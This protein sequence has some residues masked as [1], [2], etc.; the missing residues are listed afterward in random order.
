VLA[1]YI[2]FVF[3]TESDCTLNIGKNV[4]YWSGNKEFVMEGKCE[5]L[6]ISTAYSL[7]PLSGKKPIWVDDANEE[8]EDVIW[9]DT[10]PPP[11]S[12]WRW[13]K[14]RHIHPDFN[15]A[16][17]A[18]DELYAALNVQFIDESLEGETFE[19][20]DPNARFNDIVMNDWW[21]DSGILKNR[22]ARIKQWLAWLN[23][24]ASFYAPTRYM[25]DFTD[26]LY[27]AVLHID[28]KEK[29]MIKLPK[30]VTLEGEV[31]FGNGL[32]GKVIQ[33]DNGISVF[34]LKQYQENAYAPNFWAIDYLD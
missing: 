8:Y 32:A 12:D 11:C 28:K 3:L 34:G 14:L 4:Q 7:S 17:S 16:G 20:L 5:Y 2:P 19:V 9:V 25:S 33:K 24:D 15:G 23:R 22:E 27:D 10:L 30:P 29:R 13:I 18:F 1:V 6:K 21:Y 31:Y 26:E